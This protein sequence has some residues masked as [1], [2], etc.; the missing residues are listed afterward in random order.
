MQS[1]P[2]KMLE[3]RDY[4][5]LCYCGGTIEILTNNTPAELNCKAP[6]AMKRCDCVELNKS[7]KLGDGIK[8]ATYF[9]DENKDKFRL[10]SLYLSHSSS[11]IMLP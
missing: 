6:E 3:K 9:V 1:A 2:W 10:Q 4:I 11:T 8:Q 7:Q 5:P